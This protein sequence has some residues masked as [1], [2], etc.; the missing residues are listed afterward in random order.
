M[1]TLTRALTAVLLAGLGAYFASNYRPLDPDFR[2]NG[3]FELVTAGT[4]AT[5][6]WAFL[7]PRID[8]RYVIGAWTTLQAVV[9]AAICAMAIF[10]VVEVFQRGYKMEYRGLEE[11]ILGFFA[12]IR[13]YAARMWDAG[14]LIMVGVVSGGI[15]LICVSAFRWFEI[16]RKG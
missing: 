1:F 6:G 8:R 10:A 4:A 5:V 7:G 16:R 15:G 11:A 14:F 3:M 9:I 2:A 12:I 13:T